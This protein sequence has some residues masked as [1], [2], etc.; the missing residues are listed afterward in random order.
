[1]LLM[2]QTS[3]NNQ[4]RPEKAPCELTGSLAPV[5]GPSGAE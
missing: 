3:W 2:Q 4:G 1:M 5:P